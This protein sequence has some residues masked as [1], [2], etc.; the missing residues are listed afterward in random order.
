M[1][2]YV[3]RSSRSWL[4][5][6]PYRIWV[7]YP[8]NLVYSP[9]PLHSGHA[10]LSLVPQ[11]HQ[12][13]RAFCPFCLESSL[14][15]LPPQIVLPYNWD[16]NRTETCPNFLIRLVLLQERQTSS[17]FQEIQQ[18]PSSQRLGWAA[19]FA[20]KTGY[21]LWSASTSGKPYH[22]PAAKL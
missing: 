12:K 9:L 10:D 4:L 15:G 19:A 22:P 20:K 14:S 16:Q 13:F 5:T 8:F 2:Y 11:L 6:R 3:Y 1:S 21:S 7:H 17:S 18:P